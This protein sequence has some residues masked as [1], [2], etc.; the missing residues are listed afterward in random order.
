MSTSSA[1]VG[2]AELGRGFNGFVV[3]MHSEDAQ[4]D[5]TLH[6]ILGALPEGE[7]WTIHGVKG[8]PRIVRQPQEKLAIMDAIRAHGRDFV[9][10]VTSSRTSFS[11]EKIF[12]E[13]MHASASIIDAYGPSN[14]K[15]Y[16]AMASLPFRGGGNVMAIVVPKRDIYAM[17]NLRC[18]RTL[19]DYE[20]NSD[21]ELKACI[22]Q[23]LQ[24]LAILHSKKWLHTD[25]KP[26]NLIFCEASK[27]FK[28]IDFGGAVDFS[29]RDQLEKKLASFKTVSRTR[30]PFAWYA[31]GVS[32]T[33]AI[34]MSKVVLM[35][36]YRS[37]YLGSTPL[38]RAADLMCEGFD[39]RV[40][41]LLERHCGDAEKAR[42]EVIA[43]S[44]PCVDTAALALAIV[45]VVMK[46]DKSKRKT[47]SAAARHRL[48]RFI[49]ER[50]LCA[51]H[52]DFMGHDAAKL[53]ALAEK[54]L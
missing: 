29:S 18:N 24:S 11:Q 8:K 36:L 52:P 41:G 32:R 25:L 40:R 26:D 5:R 37:Q 38:A 54:E 21:A 53:A 31:A 12:L 15:K 44:M 23:I 48:V 30:N 28:M 34:I 3:D 27:R 4:D 51:E 42:E 20:F 19:E 45:V 39:A 10:K 16:L 7:P 33:T 13:E 46:I 50:M 49:H 35:L 47:V 2:G 14:A 22:V 43:T 9:A 17:F 6:A 1:H